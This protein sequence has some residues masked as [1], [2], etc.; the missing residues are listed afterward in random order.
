L[1]IAEPVSGRFATA[2]PHRIKAAHRRRRKV[3]SGQSVQRY[4]DPGIGRDLSVDPVTAYD[5]GDMRFFN[6]YA[7]AFNNPYKFDDPDGRCPTC[8][9][10]AGIGALVGGGIELYKQTGGFKNWDNLDGGAIA[11]ETGRGALVGALAGAGAFGA[12]ALATSAGATATGVATAEVVGGAYATGVGTFVTGP[13]S[14]LA[15]GTPGKSTAAYGKEAVNAAVGA[16]AGGVAGKAA[17]AISRTLAKSNAA[18]AAGGVA[19][20]AVEEGTSI[21][22]SGTLPGSAPP[23]RPDQKLE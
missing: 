7:Y 10:G 22:V 21:T 4:Y 23:I 5:S 20:R 17:G 16:L 1:G 18:S 12:G 6:R 11:V 8:A 9:I 19:A 14:D 3:A 15:K 2:K 13:A